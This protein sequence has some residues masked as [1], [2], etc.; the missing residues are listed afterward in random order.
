MGGSSDRGQDTVLERAVGK[1]PVLLRGVAV[2][3]FGD[4]SLGDLEKAARAGAVGDR[5]VAAVVQLGA[6]PADRILG[7]R[8]GREVAQ[9]VRQVVRLVHDQVDPFRAD[10]EPVQERLTDVRMEEEDVRG[11]DEA[12]F[13]DE[14]LRQLIGAQVLL[15]TVRLELGRGS[16]ASG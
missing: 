16:R 5:E 2:D 11:R 4:R 3:Q 6:R 1:D 7:E 12:R 14:L 13:R 8:H 9:V 10:P 15:G